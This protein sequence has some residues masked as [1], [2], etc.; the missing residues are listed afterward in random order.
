M[1]ELL[2]VMYLL[3][4]YDGG[5]GD[6]VPST[7]DGEASSASYC[8]NKNQNKTATSHTSKNNKRRLDLKL[9]MIMSPIIKYTVALVVMM[10]NLALIIDPRRQNRRLVKTSSYGARYGRWPILIILVCLRG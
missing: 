9:P 3:P 6:N 2:N 5:G 7:I 1:E 4:P 10:I 8:S